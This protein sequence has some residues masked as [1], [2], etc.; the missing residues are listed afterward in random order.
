MSLP[1]RYRAVLFDLDGTLLDTV[2]DLACSANRMLAELH[3]PGLSE[4][5]VTTFV[6][7][8]IAK[9]VE[10]VLAGSIEGTVPAAQLQAG[11]DIF[12]RCYG[13]E[14]GLRS[15]PYPGVESGLRRLAAAGMPMAI[16]TNK[17]ARFTLELL[18]RIELRQYFRVVVSGDTLAVRKPDP[19]P[20]RHACEQLGV[21]PEDALFIG[22]SR[23]DVA[24]GRG[25]G[26]AMW[27]V[28]YGYNEGVPVETLNCDRIV[29]DI[30][31]AARWILEADGAVGD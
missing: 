14:S 20:V 9:L 18:D 12:E 27:C 24:A 6:G 5:L 10:R 23:H 17:A 30:D 15:R 8:G 16:V 26:C 1:S 4:A 21:A 13:E 25:A 2:P 22:D 3:H 28:P 29:P 7:R 31:T 11:L 19:L